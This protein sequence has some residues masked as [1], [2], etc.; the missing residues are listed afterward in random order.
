MFPQEFAEKFQKAGINIHDPKYGAWWEQ[1]SHLKNAFKY[2]GRWRRFLGGS[3]TV[4]QILQ[5][6]RELGGEFGF[7]V[8][9]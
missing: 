6:G 2:N 7:Q 5:F 1:S 4:E 8:N 9:F 3:P